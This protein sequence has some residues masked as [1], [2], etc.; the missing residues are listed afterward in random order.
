MFTKILVPLDG[1]SLA[2]C[3]LPHVANIAGVLAGEVVLLRVIEAPEG[4][5][6]RP[7]DPMFSQMRRMEGSAYLA[8][9]WSRLETTGLK[10]R[11]EVLEG[12]AAPRIVEFAQ[13]EKCDLLVMSTHGRSG[14]APWSA[15]S[16]TQKVMEGVKSSV[17]LVRAFEEAGEDNASRRFSRILLPLDGS[18]RAEAVLPVAVRLAK[19]WNA[20]L[21]LLHVVARA[22]G[23][24]TAAPGDRDK[25]IE[26][27]EKRTRAE[28]TTYLRRIQARLAIKSDMKVIV[29]EKPALSIDEVV[30]DGD[31]VLASA[32]GFGCDSHRRFGSTTGELIHYGSGPLLVYQDMQPEQ[33]SSTVVEL[34][35]Q[36]LLSA[37]KNERWPLPRPERI[38]WHTNAA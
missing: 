25:L 21:L 10:V 29:G 4:M 7:A 20:K 30:S 34:A 1:S 16:V 36:D 3:V 28:A 35:A 14:L 37:R 33:I 5:A 2:E 17:L 6:H 24:H 23:I 27:L 9:I 38:D 19:D 22:P 8:N 15:G 13:A 26:E 31:L 12:S 18:Q 32:H 11:T